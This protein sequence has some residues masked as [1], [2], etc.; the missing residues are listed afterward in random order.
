MYPFWKPHYFKCPLL[1]TFANSLDP[2]QARHYV[3]PDL[4]PNCLT[5]WWYSWK[6]FSKKMF[7]KKKKKKR[8]T[9]YPACKKLNLRLLLL[10]KPQIFWGRLN[11]CSLVCGTV[12]HAKSSLHWSVIHYQLT[13]DWHS[14][15]GSE[16]SINTLFQQVMTFVVCSLSHL[17]LCSK[18]AYMA[19]TMDVKPQTKQNTIDTYI[20]LLTIFL[21]FTLLV[22]CS[23]ICLCTL[24]A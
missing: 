13:F 10:G 24:I 15:R 21:P 7:L 5:L 4:D 19:N 22:I 12:S 23:L 17:L 9:N 20:V 16:M 6:N 1:I 18:V 3:G 14:G 11:T 8:M 2:D